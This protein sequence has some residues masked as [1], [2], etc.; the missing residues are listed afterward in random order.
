MIEHSE[1]PSSPNRAQS[2]SGKLIREITDDGE[3]PMEDTRDTSPVTMATLAKRVGVH[4]STVSRALQEPRQ[5]TTNKTT[6]IIRELA[7]Q[8]DFQPDAT[9]SRLRTRRSRLIGVTVPSLTDPVHA[10]TY[11]G[12]DKQALRRGYSTML[13]MSANLDDRSPSRA[14]SLIRSRVEGIIIQDTFEGDLLPATLRKRHI[15]Y[16]MCLRKNDNEVSVAVDD[17]LG[18]RLAAEH[19]AAAG[20][21]E[22][23][24]ISP[25]SSVSTGRDRVEGFRRRMLELGTRIDDSRIVPAG[26]DIASG[27]RAAETLLDWPKLPTAIFASNDL[28]AA[29]IMFRLREAGI[30]IGRDVALVGYNDIEISKHLPV[31]LTTIASPLHEVGARSLDTLVEAIEGRTPRSLKLTPQLLARESTLA[32]APVNA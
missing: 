19:L 16:V 26:F 25:D 31:P 21:T 3:S 9:A 2:D 11:E 27:Q 29:G 18:G 15:P 8:L 1:A 32:F 24:I 14:N 22:I 23:A 6:L 4:I 10:T 20:H 12:I 5:H 30:T 7:D 13:S 28:T 17:L